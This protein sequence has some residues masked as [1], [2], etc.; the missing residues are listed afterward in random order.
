MQTYQPISCAFYDELELRALRR[1][2]CEIVYQ[3]PGQ[4][5]VT[6]TTVIRDFQT[7]DQAEYMIVANGPDIRLDW[8]VSIDGIAQSGYC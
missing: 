4:A 2:R 8:L 5:A 3:R 6:I 1:Q 7:R